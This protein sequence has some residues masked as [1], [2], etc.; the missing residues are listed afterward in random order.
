MFRSVAAYRHWF[1][2]R[3][4]WQGPSRRRSWPVKPRKPRPEPGR[5]VRL[6]RRMMRR[7]AEY[8]PAVGQLRSALKSDRLLLYA[9]RITPLQDRSLAGG[10][11]ALCA[12][13]TR[14]AHSFRRA[15]WWTRLSAIN[16]CLPSIDGWLRRRWYCWRL[17]AECSR[18]VELRCPSTFRASPSATKCSFQLFTQLLKDANLPRHC[19]SVGSQKGRDHQSGECQEHG[20]SPRRPGVWVRTR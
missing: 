15:P 3:M 14:T 2:C 17:T 5:A 20:R 19:V 11:G 4:V 12:C 18:P 10:Y 13:G 6:R 8:Q 1:R 7:H 16:Y 9:Q